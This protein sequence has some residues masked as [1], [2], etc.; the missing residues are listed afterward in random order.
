ML[1][2]CRHARGGGNK[3]IRYSA[4]DNSDVTIICLCFDKLHT[5]AWC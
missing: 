5:E 2:L 4:I 1:V 3:E